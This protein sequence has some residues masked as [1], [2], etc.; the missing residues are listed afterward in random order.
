MLTPS[1][2][3]RYLRFN[4]VYNKPNGDYFCMRLEVLTCTADEGKIDFRF[5]LNANERRYFSH[6]DF[7]DGLTFL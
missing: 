6:L 3:A 2:K 7:I 4:P 5:K 1:I